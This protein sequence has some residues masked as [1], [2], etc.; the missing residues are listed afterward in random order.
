MTNEND[1]VNTPRIGIMGKERP[2]GASHSL[3]FINNQFERASVLEPDTPKNNSQH[4][5]RQK[6]EFAPAKPASSIEGACWASRRQS[7][8]RLR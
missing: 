7:L 1:N 8:L 4:W 2:L 6:Q 3:D 5:H